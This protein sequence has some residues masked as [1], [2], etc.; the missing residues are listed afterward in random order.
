MIKLNQLNKQFNNLQV[1]RGLSSTIEQDDFIVI[2]GPNGTGK[3]TLFDIIS[4]KTFPDSGTIEI[5]GLDC[6]K[7]PEQKRASL[8]GRLFQN[9]Y[10]GSCSN[11]TIRE[12]LAMATFKQKKAGLGVGIKAFPEQV[13]E[14]FLVP[15]KLNLESMLDVP[16][17]ALSGGQRQMI[18]FIMTVLHQPKLLLLDE[19]TAALD[20]NSATKLLVF[21]K[22]Y[23]KEHRIPVLL[24]THDPMVAKHLG[25]RLWILE[26]GIIKREFGEEKLG[27]DP[28]EFFQHIDYK[29][30]DDAPRL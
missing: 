23:A 22:K 5:D 30:L 19:P 24:I 25:N 6:T 14:E 12:N 9:T 15:L 11:L 26:E 2:M 17:G 29:L 1:L 20:P 18:S 4:G 3:T 27:L 7:M 16:M 10:L 21:A 8:V 28:T 13:I